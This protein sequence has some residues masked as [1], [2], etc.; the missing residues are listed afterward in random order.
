MMVIIRLL[1]DA[2]APYAA[3]FMP[4]FLFDA[5]K[6]HINARVLAQC[7]RAGL[8][9]CLIPSKMTWLLQPLDIRAFFPFKM[10]LQKE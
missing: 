10:V 4:I 3:D 1:R 5:A 9:P 7:S 6:I 2:L 8:L